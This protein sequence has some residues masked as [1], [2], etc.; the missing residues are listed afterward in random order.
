M[1]STVRQIF[2]FSGLLKPSINIESFKLVEYAISLAG[3]DGNRTRVC[4]VPTAVGDCR[5][6]VDTQL[7]KFAERSDAELSTLRLFTQ[8]SVPDIRSHLLSQDLI[9]VGGGSV[10]NLMAVWKA[11]GLPEILAECW[12]A[13][14]VL[15][16]SSA[17]SLC[18]HIGGPTDS[19][20]DALDPF[21]EGLGLVPFSN[22]VHD[23]VTK[24]MVAAGYASGVP[25]C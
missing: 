2:A 1:T 5:E 18:W 4:Y 3:S 22:G 21:T 15:A 23:D 19:F 25:P 24:Y 13:G 10:V 9:V 8:P 16:G 14:I 17:G 7:E 6:H 11:H 12:A 20:R